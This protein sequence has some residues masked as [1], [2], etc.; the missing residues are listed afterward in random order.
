MCFQKEDPKVELQSALCVEKKAEPVVPNKIGEC[1][2]WFL[3][4][5]FQKVRAH[6][7]PCRGLAPMGLESVITARS[8]CTSPHHP[9]PGGVPISTGPLENQ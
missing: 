1:G 7:V 2:I 4:S 5:S 9:T 3:G 6:G 8:P